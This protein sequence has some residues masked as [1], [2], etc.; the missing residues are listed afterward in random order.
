M[1]P[2][3]A[4]P[5]SAPQEAAVSPSSH[6]G[7]RVRTACAAI[8]ASVPYACR[9]SAVAA[10]YA[11][12]ALWHQ[13]RALRYLDEMENRRPVPLPPAQQQELLTRALEEGLFACRLLLRAEQELRNYPCTCLEAR[14]AQLRALVEPLEQQLYRLVS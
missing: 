13:G 10:H 9:G 5:P 8:E 2:L 12:Q 1:L 14:L 6:C 3:V 7:D 11:E 4:S